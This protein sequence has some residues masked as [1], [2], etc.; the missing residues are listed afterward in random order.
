MH[1][2]KIIAISGVGR[3]GKDS[4]FRFA[5]EYLHSQGVTT[6]R[7]AFADEL[8]RDMDSF[9]TEKFGF[10]A[11]TE[12]TAEKNK[13]RPLLVEYGRIR[14]NE[15]RGQH[16][17]KT[18]EPSILAEEGPQV[19]FI[20]DLR[21]AKYGETDELNFVKKSGGNVIHVRRYST[22]GFV[23]EPANKEEEDNDP[24]IWRAA[25]LRF[26]W[27]DW[28]Q[29]D[30]GEKLARAEVE[31]VMGENRRFWDERDYTK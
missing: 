10:S 25:D 14:R 11:F 16:W 17:L 9:I 8:K 4:F 19:R 2:F 30:G 12:D 3:A 29:F 13:I 18:I 24:L 5:S 15:S 31:R 26:E 28:S 21:F 23:Q 6:G 22:N 7:W 27:A 20:T 1:N